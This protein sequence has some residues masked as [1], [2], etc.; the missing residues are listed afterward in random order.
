MNQ[1]LHVS[2]AAV[3]ETENGNIET[4]TLGAVSINPSEMI[5]WVGEE[6]VLQTPGAKGRSFHGWLRLLAVKD[7]KN[8]PEVSL[9]VEGGT[10]LNGLVGTNVTIDAAQIPLPKDVNLIIA[11]V[12]AMGAMTKGDPLTLKA[13]VEEREFVAEKPD[14]PKD[15]DNF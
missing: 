10:D 4:I 7:T 12:T 3:K 9:K 15:L 1:L 8:G 13:K 6:V 11:P 2:S 5:P 14:E